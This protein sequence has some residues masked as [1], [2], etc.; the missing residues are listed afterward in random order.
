MG[1]RIEPSMSDTVWIG[2]L[3][4][5]SGSSHKELISIVSF[6]KSHT[7]A[8]EGIKIKP[9]WHQLCFCWIRNGHLKS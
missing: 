3:R 6:T 8:N 9:W 5:F 4:D 1:L 7:V 2:V